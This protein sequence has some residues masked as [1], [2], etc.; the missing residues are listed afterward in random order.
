MPAP[1]PSELLRG[2]LRELA[3]FPGGAAAAVRY[4]PGAEVRAALEAA[5]ASANDA[6]GASF[7]LGGG[8]ADEIR[9]QRRARLT[10]AIAAATGVPAEE[11]VPFGS[12]ATMFSVVFSGFSRSRDRQPGSVMIPAP[13]RSLYKWSAR[14]AGLKVVE[15][16]LDAELRL[17]VAMMTRAIGTLR[18]SVIVLGAPHDGTGLAPDPAALEQLLAAAQGEALV[19][20][21]ESFAPPEESRRMRRSLAPHLVV[22]RSFEPWLAPDLASSWLELAPDLARA[23]EVFPAVARPELAATSVAAGE[24]LLGSPAREMFAREVSEL[25]AAHDRLRLRLAQIE[26]VRPL[27]GHSPFV[28][29]VHDEPVAPLLEQAARLGRAGITGGGVGR[30][31]RLSRIA[32]ADDA[33]AEQMVALLSGRGGEGLAR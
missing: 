23:L 12:L 7:D 5:M 14:A 17:D 8:G 26:G 18:P 15:V 33:E 24:A 19:V 25:L 9:V 29:V 27:A 28:A 4:R 16:P 1:S 3:P 22:V 2:D 20:L 31:A 13:A 6:K 32:I 11:V 10:S 21:D 30:L